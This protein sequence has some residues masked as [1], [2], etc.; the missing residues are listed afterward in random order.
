ML[1]EEDQKDKYKKDMDTEG[2]YLQ[3]KEQLQPQLPRPIKKATI[4]TFQNNSSHIGSSFASQ[5]NVF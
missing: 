1:G 5:M 4:V 3:S 2:Q